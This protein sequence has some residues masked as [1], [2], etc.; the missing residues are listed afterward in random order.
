MA[1]CIVKSHL[2]KDSLAYVFERKMSKWH[3][4]MREPVTWTGNYRQAGIFF[5]P[6]SLK[7]FLACFVLG[8]K[9]TL[10]FTRICEFQGS[11]VPG[12]VWAEAGQSLG[13]E[14]VGTDEQHQY[15]P[16]RGKYRVLEGEKQFLHLY[17][18]TQKMRNLLFFFITFLF[19]GLE[20]RKSP[21][22]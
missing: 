21:Q 16:T 14:T 11:P 10:H 13:K 22:R 1:L 2:P 8:R 18:I 15:F 4:A 12:N 5:S 20:E 7:F 17:E 3:L 9:S 6:V 19:F